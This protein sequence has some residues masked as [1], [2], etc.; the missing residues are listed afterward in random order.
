MLSPTSDLVLNANKSVDV[1]AISGFS[2]VDI[3]PRITKIVTFQNKSAVL[4]I[5]RTHKSFN[6]KLTKHTILAYLRL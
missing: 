1:D 3:L 6:G 2:K 4:K 5:K